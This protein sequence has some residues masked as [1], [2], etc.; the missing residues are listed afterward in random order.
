MTSD[1]DDFF[2]D[3]VE[4]AK[5]PKKKKTKPPT[6][7]VKPAR[8]PTAQSAPLTTGKDKNL[9]PLQEIQWFFSEIK[10][11]A[12]TIY[13]GI[14]PGADGG[15]AFLHPDK[16]SRHLVVDMPT[17]KVA[18][19]GKKT[20]KGKAQQRTQYDLATIWS[21]FQ[22]VRDWH[23]RVLVCIERL[24]PRPLD[25]PLTGFSLG[26]AFHMWPLFLYSHGIACEEVLPAI[27]KRKLGLLGKDKEAS[28]LKA[29]K[30]F[31]SASLSRKKDDGRAEA[32][33]IAEYFRIVRSK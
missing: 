24:Q 16:P 14:D 12:A 8:S 17:T 21:Y 15:I 19:Q 11:G 4:P 23:E 30:L 22:I 5:S 1:W 3:G 33:L 32:L 31:P 29:Q 6:K 26:G 27:W 10:P 9:D 20:G 18:I 13:L 25:T 7:I 28:R 2:G